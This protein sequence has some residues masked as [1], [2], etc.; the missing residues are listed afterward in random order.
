MVGYALGARRREFSTRTMTRNCDAELRRGPGLAL[1]WGS[2]GADAGMDSLFTRRD[3]RQRQL[4]VVRPRRRAGL[5]DVRLHDLRHSFASRGLE[6]GESLSTLGKL[7]GHRKMSSTARY[8][9][10]VRDAE[11]AAAARVGASM[12][13]HLDSR[14]TQAA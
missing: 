12:E 1:R 9:H 13:A 3:H 5:E 8:A 6:L 4:C 10:L 7:L 11:R 14:D 2:G